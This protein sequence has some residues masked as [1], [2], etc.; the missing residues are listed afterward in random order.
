MRSE[1]YEKTAAGRDVPPR[2]LHNRTLRII[3]EVDRLGRHHDPDCTGWPNHAPALNTRSTA[4][5][6]SA[7]A[8]RPIR[9]VTP[10]ISTSMMPTPGS[11]SHH[12]ALRRRRT[13]ADAGAAATAGTNCSPSVFDPTAS[14]LCNCRRQP[15]SCCGDNPCRR[16]T[17]ETLSP[18]VIISPTIRALSSAL[19]VRRRPRPVNTSSR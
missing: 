16:A 12:G 19:H 15:N 3:A 17:P 13:G 2:T 10:A 9:T 4:A 8:P 6:V 14:V 5:T 18:L 1:T 11:A 7:S